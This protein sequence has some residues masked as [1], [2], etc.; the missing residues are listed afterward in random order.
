MHPLEKGLQYGNAVA[1]QQPETEAS[2]LSTIMSN[3]QCCFGPTES[4]RQRELKQI[5]G[6]VPVCCRRLLA[7]DVEETVFSG[8]TNTLPYTVRSASWLS[9]CDH[10]TG[11]T[12]QQQ[13]W[14]V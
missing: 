4:C 3:L 2:D 11:Q 10:D 14:H 7:E 8:R 9:A 6:S 12:W 13:I 1:E 5:S